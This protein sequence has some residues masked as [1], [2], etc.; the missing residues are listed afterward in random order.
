MLTATFIPKKTNAKDGIRRVN[1]ETD[2]APLADLIE[3]AFH[4]TMDESGRAAIREM[5]YLSR[6]GFGLN[7]LA[8][9]NDLVL[10]IS[11]GYVAIVD[12]KLVGNVSVY[13][14]NWRKEIGTAWLVANVSTHPDYRKRGIARTLMQEAM[15]FIRKKR[16]TDAI[17]QVDYDNHHAIHLYETL[18]FHKE[19]A[20]TKWGRS[21]LVSSP[22][23][24]HE[25]DDIFFTKP[26][27]SDWQAEYDL[28]SATRANERGGIGWLR[29][30]HEK[31][32]RPSIMRAVSNVFSF[33]DQERLIVRADED[34]HL[35]ASLW[36]ERSLALSRTKVTLFRQPN[37]D[38]R[39]IEAL[40]SNILRRYRSASFILEHPHDDV[41]ITELVDQ[42]RFRP[43]RTVWHMRYT[44]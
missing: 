42:Y 44:Y 5:R 16:A 6:L 9:L 13:P 18:G 26:R 22:Q 34:S 33:S 19:R 32:F 39:Y 10:G 21:G 28:V 41:P 38:I 17:L 4:E 27:R 12:G 30:I 43:R 7:L 3:L 2:L 15:R 24:N 14:A 35:L 1:I 36:T 20:F 31:D 23:R 8:R 25:L 11:Q 29:P 40:L 37:M